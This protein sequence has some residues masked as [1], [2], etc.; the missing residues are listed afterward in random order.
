M[1]QT[2]SRNKRRLFTLFVSPI[3]MR[4]FSRGGMR[5]IRNADATANPFIVR[6]DFSTANLGD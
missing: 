5:L 4:R 2:R 3:F 6:I 1:T